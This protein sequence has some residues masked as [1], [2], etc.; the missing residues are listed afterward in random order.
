MPGKHL[1]FFLGIRVIRQGG[2]WVGQTDDPPGG[3][4]EHWG[5]GSVTSL[6]KRVSFAHILCLTAYKGEIASPPHHYRLSFLT[7]HTEY[8]VQNTLEITYT[9]NVLCIAKSG[10]CA[11]CYFKKQHGWLD[12]LSPH[13]LSAYLAFMGTDPVFTGK[14]WVVCGWSS[15]KHAYIDNTPNRCFPGIYSGKTYF[16]SIVTCIFYLSSQTPSEAGTS[17]FHM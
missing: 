15:R 9:H 1:N 10:N 2:P 7:A 6:C 17:S 8:M 14:S 16:W 5:A 3:G 4:P 11:W 13:S 12:A